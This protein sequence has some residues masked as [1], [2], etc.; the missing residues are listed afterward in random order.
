MT[1]PGRLASP[2]EVQTRQLAAQLEHLDGISAGHL[3][4]IQQILF[5]HLGYPQ[6]DLRVSLLGVWSQ[7]AGTLEE[8]WSLQD[9][10]MTVSGINLGLIWGQ[11][12]DTWAAVCGGS[13]TT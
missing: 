10:K 1:S 7:F 2:G 9:E 13:S 4:I 3:G 5:R 6:A 11:D 12:L 8:N